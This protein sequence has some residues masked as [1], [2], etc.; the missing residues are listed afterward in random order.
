MLP[1]LL[2]S[3]SLLQQKKDFK[4][5]CV[6]HDA[7]HPPRDLARIAGPLV[8]HGIVTFLVLS[9]AAARMVKESVFEL[10]SGSSSSSSS[11]GEDGVNEWDRVHLEVFVPIFPAPR[12]GIGRNE[13]DVED[14]EA[15]D[16][17][18][19][20]VK[21]KKRVLSSVI[22]QGNIDQHRRDYVSL[23]RDLEEALERTSDVHILSCKK[24]VEYQL[25]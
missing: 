13:G 14:L 2:A 3:L 24:D 10:A 4:I 21:P 25:S 19:G 18:Y 20:S 5:L 17:V 15:G 12:L 1:S 8:E 22:V 23:F 11:D 6:V 9:D 16:T 7:A